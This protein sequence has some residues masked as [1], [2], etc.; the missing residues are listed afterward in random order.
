MRGTASFLCQPN[1]ELSVSIAGQA[2]YVTPGT[3]S[4][5]APANVTSVCVVCIG[6]GGGVTQPYSN[7]FRAGAGGSLGYKNNIP[8][9]PGNTYTVVVGSGGGTNV[10]GGASSFSGTGFTTLSAP[11]GLAGST[12]TT[13][14]ATGSDG[15]GR[16]GGGGEVDT[17]SGSC[18]GGGGAGGYSGNGG[19]GT[20]SFAPSQTGNGSTG[21]GGGGGGGGS[22]GSFNGG[23]GGGTG[24]YGA[25]ANGAGGTVASP[26]GKGGSGGGD[27][28]ANSRGGA[29]GGGG[30][31]FGS[32]IRPGG[33]GA[34]RIIWGGGRA[35]PSTNTGN[36]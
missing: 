23:C 33:H 20:T 27:G 14:A 4:W 15:G 16:G 9:T 12:G 34:V 11:G 31:V 28:N 6:A 10:N 7:S 35:F 22:S 17:A 13:A 3:H 29:Y 5:V 32:V 18:S 2:E 24:I 36:V 21:S 30:S 19:Q 25:G 1:G 8:V 26:Q